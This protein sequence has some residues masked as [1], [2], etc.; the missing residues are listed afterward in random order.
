MKILS[1]NTWGGRA[2]KEELLDFFATKK[3]TIDIFCLQEVWRK[4]NGTY[5][6][7]P[8]GGVTID[9]SKILT[10]GVGD[11][12]KVLQDYQGYFHPQVEDHYGLY[13]LTAS[14]VAVEASG[15]EFVHKWRGFVPEGDIGKHARSVQ[16]VRIK[17]AQGPVTIVNFHGLW[18]GNGKID[19]ADRIEQSQNIVAFLKKIDGP[20][21]LMGDFNLLPDTASLQIIRDSGARDL[22]QEYGIT[23][24]R[25]ALYTK[26][27]RH[28]NY[29]FVSPELSV[30]DFRVLPDEVSDHAPLLLDVT[31]V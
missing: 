14:H 23:S 27:H 26:T 1:L 28:A 17:T 5:T 25:T 15:E 7:M 29:V 30:N 20:Y 3:D 19:S 21:V 8:A 31:I 13:T 9:L 18:N 10:D 2:G 16:Y 22:V 12:V 4:K 6:E 24:T 11:I